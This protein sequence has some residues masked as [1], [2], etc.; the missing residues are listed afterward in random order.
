MGK[1]HSLI[2]ESTCNFFHES[3]TLGRYGLIEWLHGY[4][5]AR[6]SYYY[7][8]IRTGEHVLVKRCK[9]AGDQLYRLFKFFAGAA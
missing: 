9:P 3:I 4:I 1:Q 2:K 5:Y 7:I 8:G 6:W